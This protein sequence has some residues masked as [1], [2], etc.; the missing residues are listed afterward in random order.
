MNEVNQP[1]QLPTSVSMQSIQDRVAKVSYH[2]MPGTTTTFCQVDMVNGYTIWGMSACVD[3]TKYNQALGEKYSFEDA[4][5][6][7]WP[8]EGYLLAERRHQATL[9]K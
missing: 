2:L 1:Q 6:K 3:P 4:L 7:A 8:L 5:N 9:R